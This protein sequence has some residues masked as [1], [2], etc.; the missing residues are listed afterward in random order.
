MITVDFT[1]S[2]DI[3]ITS[4]RSVSAACRIVD[5]GCLM[6]RLTTS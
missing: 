2:P 6:P 3:P 4:A 1:S 5:I